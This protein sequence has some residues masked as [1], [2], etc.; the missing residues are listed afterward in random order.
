MAVSIALGANA[1]RSA[2]SVFVAVLTKSLRLTDEECL[3]TEG[4]SSVGPQKTRRR[5]SNENCVVR[6]GMAPGQRTPTEGGTT[7]RCNKL[8]V[9]QAKYLKMHKK[10]QNTKPLQVVNLSEGWAPPG[11]LQREQPLQVVNLSEGWLQVVDE[12]V[13]D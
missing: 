13:V 7:N 3:T 5:A 4:R 6:G 10:P 9:H 11:K 8:A 12:V 2:T 1:A